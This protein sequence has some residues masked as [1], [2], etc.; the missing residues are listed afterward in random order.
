M[1]NMVAYQCGTCN[2]PDYISLCHGR[3]LRFIGKVLRSNV[4]NHILVYT[5]VRST[6]TELL[7]GDIGIYVV[8]PASGYC[9]RLLCLNGR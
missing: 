3:A 7:N 6:L 2:L 4:I 1:I 9:A 5:A 8:M